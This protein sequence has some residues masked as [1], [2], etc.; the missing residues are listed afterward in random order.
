MGRAKVLPIFLA[1]KFGN[2][3]LKFSSPTP[4]K[5]LYEANHRREFE[6]DCLHRVEKRRLN[7]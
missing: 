2:P 7:T 6:V 3:R 4:I 1:E 5:L